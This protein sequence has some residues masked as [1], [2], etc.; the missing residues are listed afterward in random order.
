MF[1]NVTVREL[2]ADNIRMPCQLFEGA[3]S[4][5]DVVR[6]GRVMVSALNDQNIDRQRQL[7]FGEPT[8]GLE[9][10]IDRQ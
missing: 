2:T 1:G 7:Y 3:R 10:A 8:S 6:D 5:G 4:D 9:L